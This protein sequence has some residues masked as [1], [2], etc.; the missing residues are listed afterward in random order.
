MGDQRWTPI[1]EGHDAEQAQELLQAI[2]VELRDPDCG[3]LS[4]PGVSGGW[5]GTALLHG[6]LALATGE[7]EH[8]E[9]ALAHLGRAVDALAEEPRSLALYSGI[10][11]AVWAAGR[12]GGRLLDVEE[13]APVFAV[14]DEQLGAA[15][16][17]PRW[18]GDYDLISGLV[19]HVVYW[20]AR[21]PA[22]AARAALERIVLHLELLAEPGSPGLTWKTPP[23]RLPEWQR[24]IAPQGY[25]NAGL[26]HGVPGIIAVLGELCAADVARDRARPLLDGAVAWLLAQRLPEGAGSCFPSWLGPGIEPRPARLAWCYGDLGLACAL[27][28]AARCCAE[29][30]WE[31]EALAVAREAAGRPAEKAGVVDAG[32]CHGAAGNA[33]LFNRLFQAT[34]EECFRDASRFWLARTLELRR[35]GQGVAG[36]AS[37]EPDPDGPP[38]WND[39]PGLLTGATGVGLA[40]LA[41]T[42]PLE[43]DWDRL[44]LVD[45]PRG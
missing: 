10:T 1:L 11:G 36:I 28:R 19:G 38:R 43:P 14:V 34:R 33:H 29:P 7:D 22:P 9:A 13:L 25:Y 35:P 15:L 8:A 24:E 23:E 41:A 32:L 45:L 40:L 30:S 27:L 5:A 16:E 21:L 4:H 12:L 2:A 42:Q 44:L 3:W 17:A 26:A 37:Y 18:I 20:Q 31:A 6:A 39:D